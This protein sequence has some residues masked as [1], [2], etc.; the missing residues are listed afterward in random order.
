MNFYIISLNFPSTCKNPQSNYKRLKKWL[1]AT[2][3]NFRWLIKLLTAVETLNLLNRTI[4]WKSY[5]YILRLISQTST[6]NEFQLLIFSCES[7]FSLPC[8]LR[9][10]YKNIQCLVDWCFINHPLLSERPFPQAVPHQLSVNKNDERDKFSKRR[11]RVAMFQLK[12]WNNRDERSRHGKSMGAFEFE[13]LS[14]FREAERARARGH[15]LL[16]GK[17]TCESQQTI[18]MC[19]SR[20][21]TLWPHLTS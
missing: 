13:P 14:L 15:T 1:L 21:S 16:P 19:G 10:N 4:F 20:F 6:I 11:G 7:L 18:G 9:Y 12:P 2:K 8:R 3:K 5:L 17:L